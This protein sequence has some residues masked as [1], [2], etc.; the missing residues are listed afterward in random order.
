MAFFG[1]ESRV[2]RNNGPERPK[3]PGNPGHW[4]VERI[5]AYARRIELVALRT[6]RASKRLNV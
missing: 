4:A 3:I 5:T 2:K 6:S 1:P